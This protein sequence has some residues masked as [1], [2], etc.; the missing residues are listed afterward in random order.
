V[1]AGFLVLLLLA[2]LARAQRARGAL[3]LLPDSVPAGAAS[4]A[5]PRFLQ[6]N[7]L[8][9]NDPT[10]TQPLSDAGCTNVTAG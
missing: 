2:A 6:Y 4:A 9:V 7:F 8:C 5:A 1:Q 10:T 3:D